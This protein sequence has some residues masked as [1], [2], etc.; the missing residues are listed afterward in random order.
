MPVVFCEIEEMMRISLSPR[1]VSSQVY[2]PLC[3]GM[4]LANISVFSNQKL[5]QLCCISR[6]YSQLNCYEQ[7]L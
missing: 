2:L 7:L 6:S 5:S 4:T 3:D 1:K